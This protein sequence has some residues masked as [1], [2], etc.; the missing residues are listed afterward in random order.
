MEPPGQRYVVF[1]NGSA[2]F[3]GPPAY[4]AEEQPRPQASYVV[5]PPPQAQTPVQSYGIPAAKPIGILLLI[6]AVFSGTL[7]HNSTFMVLENDFPAMIY[8]LVGI[9]CFFVV[10]A[11]PR[12]RGRLMTLLLTLSCMTIAVALHQVKHHDMEV[13]LLGCQNNKGLGPYSQSI[14][15]MYCTVD[16]CLGHS[17][18]ISLRYRKSYGCL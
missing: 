9:L 13:I 11:S 15:T 12:D 2:Q 8:G 6:A 5:I 18:T 16:Y 14:R 3:Q 17:G 1:Q 10:E 7:G 4:T